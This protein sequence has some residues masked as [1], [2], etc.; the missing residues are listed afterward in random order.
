[1]A[2]IL[3]GR[4]RRRDVLAALALLS[5]FWMLT[6]FC[7]YSPSLKLKSPVRMPIKSNLSHY[8][9]RHPWTNVTDSMRAYDAEVIF[10]QEHGL[11]PLPEKSMNR[12][13]ISPRFKTTLQGLLLTEDERG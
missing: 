2:V 4:P 13:R 11:H 10:P 5:I 3:L 6:P 1:M 8:A 7:R 9:I 12:P